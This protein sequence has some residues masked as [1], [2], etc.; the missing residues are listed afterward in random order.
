MFT[1]IKDRG[2]KCPI[3]S[4]LVLQLLLHMQYF[5]KGVPQYRH[6][7]PSPKQK[8]SV[9]VVSPYQ[10]LFVCLFRVQ[11]FS[12]HLRIFPSF[13]DV[14]IA[15]EGF[16]ISPMLGTYGHWAVGS[17][18]VPHLL[19]HV[20]SVYYGRLRRPVTHTPVTEGLSA[21]LSLPVLTT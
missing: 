10:W 5:P 21:K 2:F 14:T 3:N 20:A 11:S 12:S 6:L 16:K 9:I 19:W 8:S 4:L 1:C 13:G 15:D 18:C 17:F 7:P